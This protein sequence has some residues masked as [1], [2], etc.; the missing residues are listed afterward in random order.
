MGYLLS[1]YLGAF[2]VFALAM[3]TGRVLFARRLAEQGVL[4]LGAAFSNTGMPG[5]PLVMTAFG[6]SAALPLFVLQA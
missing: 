4:G 3:A 1:Y 2:A 5:I 6:P